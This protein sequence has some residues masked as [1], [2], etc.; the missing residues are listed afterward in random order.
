MVWDVAVDGRLAR[1]GRASPGARA[2]RWREFRDAFAELGE[3]AEP[4]FAR[5]WDA[6]R[7]THAELLAL[8]GGAR[9]PECPLCR[10]PSRELDGAASL[11]PAAL[12]AVGA[13]FPSW[14]PEA[15]LCR[16]CAE[17]YQARATASA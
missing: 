14:N 15:G 9:R 7:V 17:I 1:R 13:D 11:S 16:R 5:V 2:D 10:L 4:I 8:A 6:D 12:G 3:S